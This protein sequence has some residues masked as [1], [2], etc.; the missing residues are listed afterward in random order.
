[1]ECATGPRCVVTEHGAAREASAA[2]LRYRAQLCRMLLQSGRNQSGRPLSPREKA[3]IQ[4]ELVSV[5]LELLRRE[6]R[7]DP[8]GDI[9]S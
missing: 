9:R 2:Q 1:M 5:S 7:E 6:A 8:Y 3:D 4:K